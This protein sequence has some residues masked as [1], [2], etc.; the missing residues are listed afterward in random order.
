LHDPGRNVN[1]VDMI[2]PDQYFLI[3]AELLASHWRPALSGGCKSSRSVK[4]GVSAQKYR[5]HQCKR[6][7]DEGSPP[8]A[9]D[10]SPW[11]AFF[12][13]DA[14]HHRSISPRCCRRDRKH[15]KRAI[16]PIVLMVLRPSGK[17]RKL[18]QCPPTFC[19]EVMNDRC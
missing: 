4:P 7:V 8:R 16:L 19:Q 11:R 12:A 14:C 1:G 5:R 3:R 17:A 10:L 2:K 15:A 13:P 18:H 6:W 9:P